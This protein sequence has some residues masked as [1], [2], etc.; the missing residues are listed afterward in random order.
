MIWVLLI[1][2]SIAALSP[3]W[4]PMSQR[5][6][7]SRRQATLALY[8]S[9]LLELEHNSY[10]IGIT[11]ID[12]QNARTEVERRLLGANQRL[13]DDRAPILYGP[14]VPA[15]CGAIVVAAL[16]LYL[17]FGSP[18]LPAAPLASRS[19]PE[20]ETAQQDFAILDLLRARIAA[21]PPGSPQAQQGEALLHRL[22]A[23]M[24]EG[25][26]ATGVGR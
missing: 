23:D 18:G 24:R 6:L 4:F 9:Q 13:S 2:F 26:G 11:G 12:R 16:V 22:E 8:R 10:G 19:A 25:S 5:V 3:V 21:L 7:T 20:M 15:S 17:P 1:C 14:L